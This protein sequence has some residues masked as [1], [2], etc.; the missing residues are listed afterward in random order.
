MP[1][2]VKLVSKLVILVEKTIKS[3]D[4]FVIINFF[5]DTTVYK[6]TASLP[7]QTCSFRL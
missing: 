2:I 6:K 1:M 4:F 3:R 7:T 5:Y